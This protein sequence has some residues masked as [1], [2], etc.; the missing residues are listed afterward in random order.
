MKDIERVQEIPG[1]EDDVRGIFNRLK[2]LLSLAEAG[3]PLQDDDQDLIWVYE[4]LRSFKVRAAK[5]ENKDSNR[6]QL[7]QNWYWNFDLNRI[8]PATADLDHDPRDAYAAFQLF[9]PQ[10]LGGAPHREDT[11]VPD[12]RAVEWHSVADLLR[13]GPEDRQFVIEYDDG[14]SDGT[15]NLRFG[16][17]THGMAPWPGTHFKA[18]YREGG[19]VAGNVGIDAIRSV[20]G[21]N[22]PVSSIDLVSNPFPARG[23]VDPE[24]TADARFKA[25]QHFRAEL[26]RA[27]TADDYALLATKDERVHNATATMCWTGT[28]YEVQVALDIYAFA[29]QNADDPIQEE[30]IIRHEVNSMLERYRSIGHD[31]LVVHTR[32]V[33]LQLELDI[34]VKPHA[35]QGNVRRLVRE[36][37][38]NR[39]LSNGRMGYFHPDRLTFGQS[40]DGSSIIAEVQRVPDVDAVR[41]VV[42]RR[43][44]GPE[45]VG[46]L[47][48]TLSILPYEIAR[49]DNDKSFPEN[50][51]L[52]LN[53]R[54]GR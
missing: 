1:L 25:P 41:L 52:V 30:T 8:G 36:V 2:A 4:K 21:P 5:L 33:P 15:Y 32:Y 46:P 31:V 10:G 42:L 13:S 3:Q 14:E 53:L 26:R 27:I 6:K 20:V 18:A 24:P 45:H 50:G 47:G 38:G 54:G 11:K 23:G 35:Q 28:C 40:I 37:L 17:G 7:L 34:C 19:G 51:R 44:F 29:L 16:D 39:A 22:G 43:L 48:G 9:E 49:L 12:E